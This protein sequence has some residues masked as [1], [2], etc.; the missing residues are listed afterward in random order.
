MQPTGTRKPALLIVIIVLAFLYASSELLSLATGDAYLIF[1]AL[2]TGPLARLLHAIETAVVV[3]S[4]V[5]LILMARW[6]W[7][8]AVV[9]GAFLAVSA[10]VSLTK[11]SEFFDAAL[12]EVP[13][14]PV[15]EIKTAIVVSGTALW[16]VLCLLMLAAVAYLVWKRHLFGIG[17]ETPSPSA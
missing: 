8:L 1:T 14:P 3:A 16:V 9:S 5:G 10:M 4:A 6:G 13:L 7:W 2:V 11:V 12:A 17:V 15:P